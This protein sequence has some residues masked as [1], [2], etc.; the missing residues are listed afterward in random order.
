MTQQTILITGGTGATGGYAVEALRQMPVTIRA[1]LRKDDERAAALRA[2]GVE[3]VFGDLLEID[4]VRAAM[5]G[6]SSAYFL[7]PLLPGLVAANAYFAQA[8][9]EAGV[10]AIV[11]M[12]QISARR[13]AGSHQARDHWIA[14]RVFDWSGVPVT[15]LRPTFFAEWLTRG[16][17]MQTIAQDNMFRLP[18]GTGRHAPIAAQD[19]GRLIAAILADPAPHAGKTY[20]LCGPVEMD[21]HGV[22]AALSE[23][24]GRTIVYE[25]MEVEAYRAQLQSRGMPEQTIQH[26]CA[27][28]L[29]YRD[30]IFEGTDRIIEAVTGIPPMSVRAFAEAHRAELGG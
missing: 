15:H 20:P 4:D 26:L 1:M 6:V 19:Q 7:Y 14:E 5:A 16:A 28:A 23:E 9:Q 27:V 13:E 2:Q 18:F 10:K 22:A 3:T 25:P 12:S 17:Q 8:A 30:G 29:D 24:L 11:N 21:Y